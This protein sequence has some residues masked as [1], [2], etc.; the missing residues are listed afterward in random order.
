MAL[1]HT[2]PKLL[3]P[4]TGPD[5]DGMTLCGSSKPNTLLRVARLA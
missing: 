4:M 3:E 2:D 1:P 5:I